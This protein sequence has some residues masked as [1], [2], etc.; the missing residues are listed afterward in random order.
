MKIRTVVVDDE[1]P[2]RDRIKRF[3]AEHADFEVSGDGEHV[4]RGVA[5][6]RSVRASQEVLAP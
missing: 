6:C 1:K 4:G 3:L 5:M 2:A